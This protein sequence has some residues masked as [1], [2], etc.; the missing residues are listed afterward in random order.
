M[1]K[2]LFPVLSHITARF[3]SAGRPACSS[4]A[5]PS[6]SVHKPR[7]DP[8][9]PGHK[10]RQVVTGQ[11]D[12]W[13]D[14]PVLTGPQSSPAPSSSRRSARP[15]PRSAAGPGSSSARWRRT[16][17]AA[18]WPTGSAPPSP[19]SPWRQDWRSDR[20]AEER[21]T[22]KTDRWR[23]WRTLME[24]RQAGRQA[25]V[26]PARCSSGVSL[27]PP[28]SHHHAPI[29][30]LMNPIRWSTISQILIRWWWW[31]WW[32]WRSSYCDLQLRSPPP[33]SSAAGRDQHTHA[34]A[35]THTHTHT[36]GTHLRNKS[37]RLLHLI[38]M[39]SDGPLW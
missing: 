21:R 37:L 27:R 28:V 20:Q 5:A 18:C 3:H 9:R 19:G 17:P 34:H 11:T 30:Q 25:A 4:R 14:R 23:S 12:R 10:H 13:S 36:P 8:V 31:W 2:N 38:E 16:R 33:L 7:S 39:I 35:R 6:D 29:D 1:I 22:R 26:R 15:P 24:L 32:W